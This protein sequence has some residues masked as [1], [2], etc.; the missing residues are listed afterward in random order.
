MQLSGRLRGFNRLSNWCRR[1]VYRTRHKDIGTLYFVFSYW[2]GLLG[3]GFRVIIRRE[4]A[5]PG[6]GMLDGQLYNLVVTAHALVMIFFL[7]IP[8][9]MGGFGN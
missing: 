7:V 8:I 5:M 9:M 4:L 3:T 6:E 1:W 2:A